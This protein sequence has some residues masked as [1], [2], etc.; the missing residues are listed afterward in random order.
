ML[1]SGR[2]AFG[3]VEAVVFE[4]PVAEALAQEAGRPVEIIPLRQSPRE[5]PTETARG[6][7]GAAAVRHSAPGRGVMLRSLAMIARAS[8]S[9]PIWT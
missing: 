9:R 6:P 8:S 2:V 3:A 7:R 5:G 4:K 1:Q